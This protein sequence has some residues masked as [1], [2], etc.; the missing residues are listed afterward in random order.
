MSMVMLAAGCWLRGVGQQR[1]TEARRALRI[2]FC[3]WR[4]IRDV[5]H[6]CKSRKKYGR[7]PPYPVSGPR[8]P[9]RRGGEVAVCPYGTRETCNVRWHLV[10]G[11]VS[12]HFRDAR[13]PSDGYAR[14]PATAA[15]DTPHPCR[16]DGDMVARRLHVAV[17]TRF[18]SRNALK[19][20]R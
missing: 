3:S 18:E 15:S 1:Q 9:Q 6:I 17:K 4:F 13:W 5:F 19:H 2:W 16:L 20:S 14:V 8:G 7:S 12:R 10:R 11:A